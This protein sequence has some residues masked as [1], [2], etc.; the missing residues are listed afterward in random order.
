MLA[1]D[2][3]AEAADGLLERYITALIAGE[4]L[5]NGEGLRQEALHLAGAVDGQLV[6]F[7]QKKTS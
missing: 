1:L 6:F 2:N 4:L 5:G 3:L 7:A